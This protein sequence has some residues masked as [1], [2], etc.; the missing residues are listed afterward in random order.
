MRY[1]VLV[2]LGQELCTALHSHTLAVLW[3][4]QGDPHPPVQCLAPCFSSVR[5]GNHKPSV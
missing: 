3:L 1:M 5:K 2:Q 4:E